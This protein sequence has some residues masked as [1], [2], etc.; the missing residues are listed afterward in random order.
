MPRGNPS[1]KLA[2]T[3]D[4]DVHQQVVLAA[5]DD[6]V[7]VSAWMTE[8][9]RRA[10]LLRDGLNAV[11][12][13]ERENVPLTTPP[14]VAQVS[15]SSRRVPLRRVLRG[16]QIEPFGREDAHPVGELCG[17]TGCSDVVDAH[18]VVVGS[19]HRAAVLTDDEADLKRLSEHLLQPIEVRPLHPKRRH[20]R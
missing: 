15:R 17:R 16:C 2:I 10:L 11:A 5:A 14:V 9:A 4:P 19:R 8:A 3:I 7:S 6:G 1:P 13:W 20:S 18:V 12:E